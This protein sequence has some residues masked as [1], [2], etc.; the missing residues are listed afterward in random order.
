M[1]WLRIF[2]FVLILSVFLAACST[3]SRVV[4]VDAE[5]VPLAV[6]ENNVPGT[7]ERLW[8]EPMY[9]NVK[10]P[11]KIDADNVYYTPSHEAIV[12]IRPGRA[13]VV[14]YPGDQ[15][16]EELNNKVNLGR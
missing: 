16:S 5:V 8:V 9:N 4:P 15:K 1:V 2:L 14:E 6:Y 7:V 12:E 3:Q 10:V 13:Q 11:G